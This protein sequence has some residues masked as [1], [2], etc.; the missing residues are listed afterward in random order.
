MSVRLSCIRAVLTGSISVKFDTKVC[1]EILLK[2]MHTCLKYPAL[3][4]KTYER[5]IVAG[6]IELLLN[7]I[8]TSNGTRLLE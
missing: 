8:F 3:Y 4:M 5:F 2:K 6:E 7:A 1:Y